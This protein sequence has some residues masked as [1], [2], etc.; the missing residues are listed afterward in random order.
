MCI[1]DISLQGG[2]IR[3]SNITQI[4]LLLFSFL[5]F[6]FISI[7]ILQFTSFFPIKVLIYSP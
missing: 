5:F 3:V 4:L 2:L 7:L 1:G 6:F